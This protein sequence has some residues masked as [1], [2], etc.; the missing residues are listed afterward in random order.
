MN[1]LML[2][3][4]IAALAAGCKKKNDDPAAAKRAEH[5]NPGLNVAPA[6]AAIPA[7]WKGKLEFV[8]QTIDNH[9]DAVTLPAPKGWKPGNIKSMLEPP[10][11]SGFG[12]GTHFWAGKTCNGECTSK[13]AAEWEK[14][15]NEMSFGNELAHTPPPK[16]LKEDKRAGFRELIAEDQYTTGQTNN[17]TILMAWWKDGADRM[18]FCNVDLAPEAKDLVPAFEQACLLTSTEF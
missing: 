4:A 8:S 14:S 16:V 5:D 6:N 2:G 10:D 12:F 9:G 11:G 1:K 17:V 7:A 15:A 3:I 18:Y 13:S